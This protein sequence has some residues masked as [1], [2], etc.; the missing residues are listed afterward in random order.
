MIPYL[1]NTALFPLLARK[2]KEIQSGND[3]WKNLFSLFV[4][5]YFLSA[6]FIS[7]LVFLLAPFLIRILFGEQFLASVSILQVFVWILLFVFPTN[8]LDFFL[9]SYHKQ[10]LDFGLTLIPALLNI[11]L[12]FTLIP[13]YGVFGAVYASLISQFLNFLLTFT[14]SFLILKKNIIIKI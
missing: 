9:I 1:F 5:G 10:W 4:L 13:S 14:A 2:V 3:K 12:N 8:F 6:L 7:F 11:F